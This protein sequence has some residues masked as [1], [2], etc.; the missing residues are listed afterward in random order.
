MPTIIEERRIASTTKDLA[1]F[2]ERVLHEWLFTAGFGISKNVETA[3][4]IKESTVVD[5]NMG[6]LR[7]IITK[8]DRQ[9]GW[10]Q[11]EMDPSTNLMGGP[12]LT[13]Y[14]GELQITEDADGID[15]DDSCYYRLVYKVEYKLSLALTILSFGVFYF[16]TQD[17]IRTLMQKDMERIQKVE[18]NSGR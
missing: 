7:W 9:A 1:K 15:D 17:M 8:V 3:A 12:A 14:K 18:A 6:G 2:T 13:L 10:I 11:Y 16:S 5:P 4:D